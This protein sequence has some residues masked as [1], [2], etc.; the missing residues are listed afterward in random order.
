MAKIDLHVSI[1][2]VVWHVV[3]KNTGLPY[4][5]VESVW[6]TET[7]ASA[8]AFTLTTVTDHEW[9][10]VRANVGIEGP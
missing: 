5:V 1:Y 8:R 4:E 6:A 10:V 2:P 9:E 7:L 3:M